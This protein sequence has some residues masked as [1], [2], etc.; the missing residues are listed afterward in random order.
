MSEWIVGIAGG[1][2]I[3]VFGVLIRMQN[4]RLNNTVTQRECELKHKKTEKSLED[5]DKRFD[6]LETKVDGISTITAK[7]AAQVEYIAKAVQR[8]ESNG[9][10]R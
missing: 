3:V 5:G 10:S 6:K 2:A 7:T 4:G 9:K 8:I 1:V